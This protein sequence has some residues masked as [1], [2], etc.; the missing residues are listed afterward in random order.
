MVKGDFARQGEK[1]PQNVWAIKTKYI[2]SG[3]DYPVNESSG[4]GVGEKMRALCDAGQRTAA[5][6]FRANCGY[7]SLNAKNRAKRQK[8]VPECPEG[9]Q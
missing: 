1:A 2:K 3:A 4:Q 8:P 9:Q 7:L 6:I 5:S